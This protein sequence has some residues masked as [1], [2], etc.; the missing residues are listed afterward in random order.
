M[1]PLLSDCETKQSLINHKEITGCQGEVGHRKG[2]KMSGL[3]KPQDLKDLLILS[4]KCLS[5][6]QTTDHDIASVVKSITWSETH[7]K[8]KKDHFS[9]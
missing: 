5:C 7:D 2:T 3:I 9:F 6:G 1:K 8:M 4:V